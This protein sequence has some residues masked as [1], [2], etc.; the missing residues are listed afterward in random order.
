MIVFIL[1][2]CAVLSVNADKA[3]SNPRISTG[4]HKKFFRRRKKIKDTQIHAD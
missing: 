4:N 3:S 2:F 1:F